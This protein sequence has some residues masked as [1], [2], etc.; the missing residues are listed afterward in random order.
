M[1][2]SISIHFFFSSIY[3]IISMSFS[4]L[5]DKD[6]SASCMKMVLSDD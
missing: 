4:I 1:S 6:D 5:L 3:G 2:K